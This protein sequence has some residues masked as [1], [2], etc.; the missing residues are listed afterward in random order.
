M[1]VAEADGRIV[2]LRAFMRWEFVAGDR[3]FRAVRAVDTATHPDYQGTGH[4]LEA[5][6]G[7]ARR[8]SGRGRLRLQH[9]ER[10][11]PARVPEDGLA[12]RRPACRSASGCGDRSGSRRGRGR[13]ERRREL[14]RRAAGR[15]PRSR[16]S[17]WT[18]EIDGLLDGRASGRDGIATPRDAAY[19][20]WRYGAAPLLDYRAVDGTR[21]R[22]GSKGSRS[23][24]CDLAGRSS[25]PR[26][27][28]RSCGAET[29]ARPAGS[30]GACGA[31]AA[32]DH[33]DVQL[34]AGI[35]GRRRPPGAPGSSA[36]PGGMTLVVNPLGHD[37]DPDPL[38]LR[39]WALSR[40]RPGGLL[41]Q[42]RRRRR[43]RTLRRRSSRRS[44]WLLIGAYVSVA[45]DPDGPDVL[46][47]L[48]RGAAGAGARR[49]VGAR[50]PPP[51]R[52]RGRP[53]DVPLPAARARR[54]ARGRRRSGTTWRSPS[55]A[56]SPTRRATT[57]AGVSLAEPFR[58][59]DFTGVHLIDRDAVHRERDRRRVRD[60]RPV[61][62][63]R[64]RLLLVARVLGAVPLLPRVH[65]R[66]ARGPAPFV[67]PPA[68]LP[69]VAG[70]LAVEHRQGGLDDV[71]PGDRRVRRRQ[72]PHAATRGAG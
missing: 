12:G 53:A 17:C 28:R 43:R 64:V 35:V 42:V 59:L 5:H 48:G 11:E 68:V 3:R 8:A 7:G 61:E 44:G 63:G 72:D 66:G 54:E 60:H 56:G 70:V 51:G 34:P 50:A 71:Q 65:D 46:R 24:G 18:D 39:S 32:V 37:L 25:R 38:D 27:R 58:H 23:S 47:R 20:R 4:L 36:S 16:R 19:L 9:A 67:R 6:A 52:A 41:M 15:A 14:G 30:S 2:G 13:G 31:S 26:S 62:A 69:P 22:A 57:A 1:L 45:A 10:E 29:G 55:T 21:A 49:R 33:V 40:G